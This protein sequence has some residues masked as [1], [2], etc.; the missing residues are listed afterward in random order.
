MRTI[1]VESCPTVINVMSH[2]DIIFEQLVSKI[3]SEAVPPCKQV[4]RCFMESWDSHHAVPPSEQLVNINKFILK[5]L[6]EKYFQ[7]EAVPPY[8]Q[9]NSTLFL[10]QIFSIV[11][12]RKKKVSNPLF[13]LC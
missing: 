3:W 6:F 1:L 11:L 5:I 8:K 2:H 12:N 13:Y 7:I 10:I 9:L 4:G